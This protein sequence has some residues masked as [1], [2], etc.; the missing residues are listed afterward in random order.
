MQ[1]VCLVYQEEQKLAALSDA[2]LD[3]ITGDCIAYI[4]E[5]SQG[6][7]HVMSSGLL[8]PRSATTIRQENTGPKITDGPFAETKEVLGGF[9]I[10]EARDLTEAIQIASKFPTGNLGSIEVRPVLDPMAEPAE[11]VDRRLA[12]SVRRAIESSMACQPGEEMGTGR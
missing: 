12:G 6:G 10:I 7:H 4:D 8:G 11:P 9:T 3:K 1:Y 2:E 5:L